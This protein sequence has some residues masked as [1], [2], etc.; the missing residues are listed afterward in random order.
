MPQR[1]ALP[2]HLFRH[3]R[4]DRATPPALAREAARQASWAITWEDE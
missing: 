3:G 1:H 2:S 4:A